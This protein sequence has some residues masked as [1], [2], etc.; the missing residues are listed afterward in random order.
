M[1][2]LLKDFRWEGRGVADLC[3][4]SFPCKKEWIDS[5]VAWGRTSEEIKEKAGAVQTTDEASGFSLGAQ[6]PLYALE[7][8]FRQR[9]SLS[10]NPD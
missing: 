8:Y 7:L 5:C 3:L 10:F 1:A 6:H 9:H 2:W 4:R